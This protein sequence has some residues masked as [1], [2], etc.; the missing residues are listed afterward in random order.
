M[1]S[2]AEPTPKVF[3]LSGEDSIIAFRGTADAHHVMT[4]G[5]VLFDSLDQLDQ[6]TQGWPIS[7][8]VGLWNRLP[9]ITVI[10]KFTDRATG[11]KRI[12]NAIQILEPLQSK[13]VDPPAPEAV[14]GKAKPGTK[15]VTLLSLLHR[16]E[17]AS[18]REIMSA[19]GWQSH[20]VRGCLSTISRQ[21]TSIHS[22][23]RADGIRVY[24]TRPE[25]N[26]N[27]EE[28]Q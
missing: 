3:L 17:G 18:V 9:D 28:A 16:P 27:A 15:K 21:G 7:R 19:L 5:D 12:W 11:L 23:R 2:K 1:K 24:S 14:T 20:S 10:R 26:S 8:L 22:F 13:Q 6:V 4:C 25:T